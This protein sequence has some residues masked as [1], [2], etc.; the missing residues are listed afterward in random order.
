VLSLELMPLEL[1][2]DAHPP[3]A[4]VVASAATLSRSVPVYR[5]ALLGRHL[6]L[7][8]AAF[9]GSN[10]TAAARGVRKSG[11]HVS[12]KELCRSATGSW[13]PV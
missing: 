9:M 4:D 6:Q 2:R 7:A 5:T 8:P 13:V 3:I 10:P 1:D 12:G 11:R